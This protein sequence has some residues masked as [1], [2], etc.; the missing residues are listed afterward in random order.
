MDRDRLMEREQS[1][2]AQGVPRAREVEGHGYRRHLVTVALLAV[3]GS[4]AL[5]GCDQLSKLFGKRGAESSSA[6]SPTMSAGRVA[7]APNEVAATVNG[8]SIATRDVELRIQELKALSE[9]AGVAWA[10]LTDEQRQAVLEELIGTELMRQDAVA[11]GLANSIEVQ[12]R[13]EY[14]QRGFL[15]QEWLQTM[16]ERLM[17]SPEEVE[18]FYEQ[19]KLGFREPIQ[20]RLRQIVVETE[21]EA[22]RALGQLLGE[23]TDFAA[24]ATQLSVGPHAAEGGMIPHWV[25]RDAEKSLF[26]V[27][28]EEALAAGIISLNPVLEAAAFA[29]DQ[30]GSFSNYVK[31][32]DGRF[33][34]FQLVERQ[35]E[36]QRSLSE[37][38]DDVKQALLVQKLQQA[39]NELRSRATINRFPERLDQISP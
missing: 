19:N 36:K 21:V 33:Y 31:G 32:P 5:A 34:V 9:N 20:I 7:V 8:A 24:L 11:R 2:S 26:Y 15:A 17:V 1:R 35:A 12:R 28:E 14:V 25:M 29:I 27:S 39:V 13:L 23:A 16:Q 37:V 3:A 22:R 18:E 38:W 6:S 30:V 4:F 10:P